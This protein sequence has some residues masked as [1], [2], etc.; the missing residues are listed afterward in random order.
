MCKNQNFWAFRDI[1]IYPTYNGTRK[2]TSVMV[3]VNWGGKKRKQFLLVFILHLFYITVK[4]KMWCCQERTGRKL[5]YAQ[6]MVWLSHNHH[7]DTPNGWLQNMPTWCELTLIIP[8][9]WRISN[10]CHTVVLLSKCPQLDHLW[11][12]IQVWCPTSW[13]NPEWSDVGHQC[14]LSMHGRWD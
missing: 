8:L 9:Q 13:L 4:K 14:V 11:G 5:N 10:V 6:M 2:H 12:H 3:Y 7:V 1:E